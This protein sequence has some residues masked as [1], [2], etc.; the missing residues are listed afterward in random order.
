MAKNDVWKPTSP[1]IAWRFI[2]NTVPE[3]IASGQRLSD[4]SHENRLE[5]PRRD[6]S[7]FLQGQ[8]ISRVSEGDPPR[9]CLEIFSLKFIG[10][11]SDYLLA[12]TRGPATV[13]FPDVYLP[14]PET[15]LVQIY[16]Q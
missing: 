11:R 10:D 9:K 13:I 15:A 4:Y 5:A 12:R 3:K 8:V 14:A 1:P 2:A 16:T 6:T 7:Q